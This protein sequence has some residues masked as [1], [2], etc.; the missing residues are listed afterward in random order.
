M[1]ESCGRS[2]AW[3]ASLHFYPNT[4]TD[5]DAGFMRSTLPMEGQS[6]LLPPDRPPTE[7]YRALP[8]I[9]SRPSAS[10]TR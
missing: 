2:I 9:T 8:A 1:Q 5:Y 4:L 6:A 7:V 10:T 3:I